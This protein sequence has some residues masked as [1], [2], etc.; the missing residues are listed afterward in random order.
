MAV[1]PADWK[2][3]DYWQAGNVLFAGFKE[4][5]E[6]TVKISNA[7]VDVDKFLENCVVLWS[8]EADDYR[9]SEEFS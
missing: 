5:P 7:V 2:T 1:S 8:Y 4:M 9:W 3:V 6:S